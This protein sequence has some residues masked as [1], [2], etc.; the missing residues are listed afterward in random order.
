[1][2]NGPSP[3]PT[4]QGSGRDHHQGQRHSPFNP[5]SSSP[6]GS[7]RISNWFRSQ[8]KHA[9]ATGPLSLE[10][11]TRSVRPTQETFE[12]SSPPIAPR[13]WVRLLRTLH[14]SAASLTELETRLGLHQCPQ[15]PKR[16]QE[17][18]CFA[19]PLFSNRNILNTTGTTPCCLQHG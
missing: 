18:R 2:G 14:E 6:R 15:H 1:M 8:K 7:I 17:P 13:G 11:A 9:A 19:P 10:Y 12:L 5:P 4:F 3:P 16:T